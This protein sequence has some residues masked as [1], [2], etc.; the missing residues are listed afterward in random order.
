M[1]GR[2]LATVLLFVGWPAQA[3]TEDFA[4]RIREGNRLM[5]AGKY[6][7]AAAAYN[8]LVGKH[9]RDPGLLAN[10]GMALHLSGKHAQAAR[11]LE[12]ALKLQPQNPPA[13]VMLG[14]SYLRLRRP[15]PARAALQKAVALAPE[16]KEG[17]QLLAETLVALGRQEEAARE[18]EQW[19]RLDP[20]DPRA[21]YGL[22]RCYDSLATEEFQ[23]VQKMAPDSGYLLA[24]LGREQQVQEQYRSAFHLYREALF[25]EPGIRG[26]HSAIAQ[27]YA[28]TGHLDWAVKEKDRERS[29]GEPD[30]SQAPPECA[31]YWARFEEAAVLPANPNPPLAARYWRTRALSELARY[32]DRKVMELG[33]SVEAHAIRAQAERDRGRTA[34]SIR[35][36]RTALALSPGNAKLEKE[37]AVTLRL[38]EDYDGARALASKLLKADPESVELNYLMG[39]IL[40]SQQQP[41]EAVPFLSKAVALKSTFLPA[42]SS[43]GLALLSLGRDTEA[44][45][46]LKASLPL[47]NDG[48]LHFRLARAFQKVG[49][50]MAAEEAMAGYRELQSKAEARKAAAVSES[51]VTGP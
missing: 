11:Q 16:M 7:E 17:H 24:L 25:R 22:G 30:C 10:L 20:R 51:Q 35:E 33:E 42:R 3:Q 26:V 40:V 15:V 47:D 4:R 6:D 37:L 44:I 29:L 28:A 19:K 13:L 9:P 46:H 43:L 45:P 49:D 39:Q 41:A 36:W 12:A 34:E 38:H 5:E 2:F 32:A 50:A 8:E 31:F 14:G 23:R 27:I 18:F 1:Q 48:S 21:W